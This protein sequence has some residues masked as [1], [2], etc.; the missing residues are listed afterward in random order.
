MIAA[1]MRSIPGGHPFRYGGEE[2]AVIF[3]GRSAPKAAYRMERFREGL[4]RT[5]FVIRRSP[6]TSKKG[7]GRKTSSMASRQRVRI[8]VSIGVAAPGKSSKKALEVLAAADKALY[9]AKK[10]GRN[11]VVG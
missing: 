2:F 1:R 10:A 6:R 5:P 9:K 11:R 3:T 7:R 8:T 4:A